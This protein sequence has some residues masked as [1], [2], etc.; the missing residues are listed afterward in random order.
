[1]SELP[2]GATRVHFI[3]GDPIAQVKSPSGVTQDFAARGHNAIVVPAHVA[4]A[5][6]ANWLACV[7]LAQN[8]DGI[9]I[10]VP[11]KF[12]SFAL[13]ATTSERGAF[14]RAVNTLRRNADGSW[15]GDMFD[16]QAFVAALQA[17]G[18]RLDGKKALLIGAGGAGSAIAY[19]LVMAGVGALAI[20]DEDVAR[21]TTLV[22]RLAGLNKCPVSHGNADPS[23][24]GVVINATPMGM[25]AADPY[26]LDVDKLT[27]DMFVGCVI[28]SP[29]V[30]PLIATA[31]SR[32]C[33]TV[34]GT[35]MFNQVR[36]LMVDF[37]SG[38]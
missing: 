12:A 18:C 25:E 24:F 10:T 33:A 1:M 30:T 38:T 6:L 34:T 16:G 7:S 31:R 29:A 36:S 23:G 35:D 27:A 11:H 20:H 8:V 37:L 22:D 26:P 9:I 14:L 15:H 17:K 5:A 2:N 3:V 19:A 32:D 4:P 28:T 21:R 13:C